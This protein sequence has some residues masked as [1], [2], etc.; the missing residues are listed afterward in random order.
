[1]RRLLNMSGYFNLHT[2]DKTC[3]VWCLYQTVHTK[4]PDYD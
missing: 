3:T 2:Y 4:I 1:M